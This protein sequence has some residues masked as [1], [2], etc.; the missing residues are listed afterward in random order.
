MWVV[1]ASTSARE[2][3]GPVVTSSALLSV[4]PGS[5]FEVV[6]SGMGVRSSVDEAGV[7]VT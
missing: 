6:A 2:E 5:G 7:V 1:R 3:G 4:S